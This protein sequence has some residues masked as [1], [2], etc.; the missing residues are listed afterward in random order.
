[1][2]NED[3]SGLLSEVG[4]ILLSEELDYLKLSE[5]LNKYKS[6]LT[7]ISELHLEDE[8]SRNDIHSSTGKAI[9]STWAAMCI[10]D[11]LRTKR[12]I[13]G[14]D[15]AIKQLLKKRK[16]PVEVLYAGSGPFA[17]LILPLTTRYTEEEIRIRLLEINKNSCLHLEKLIREL[18]L[19]EYIESI[20]NVDA[21][22]YV[23]KTSERIDILLSETMQRGLEKEQQVSIV[24][25]LLNQLNEGVIVIPEKIEL[26]L[27]IIEYVGSDSVQ[28]NY[29]SIAKVFELSKK[30]LKKY[31]NRKD[32]F[33]QIEFPKNEVEILRDNIRKNDQL[34]IFT[35]IQIYEDEKLT[36]NESGLTLPIIL[37]G[38]NKEKKENQVLQIG[39]EI[40]SNPGFRNS[41]SDSV[42][43]YAA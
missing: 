42:D 20:E 33:G 34:A 28:K 13:K 6:L 29:R 26:N 25:N 24:L 39:Y 7:E 3:S 37:Q 31:K 35:E 36:I 30:E 14:I 27:G 23:V 11:M 10:D 22:K 5:S 1:M 4:D 21:T 41:E 40:G 2:I 16:R 38:L 32:Q 9:G 15:K 17:A 19:L 8:E 12:F 18:D 43:K